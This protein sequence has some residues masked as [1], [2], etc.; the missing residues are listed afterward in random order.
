MS[1][2]FHT[3]A[4]AMEVH[5]SA[6]VHKAN[7]PFGKMFLLGFLAGAFIAFGSAS[8]SAAM[9]SIGVPSLARVVGGIVFPVGLMM[10]VFM[11]GELFTGNCL[12][13]MVVLDKKVTVWQMIVHL[14]VS[15]LSNM[16]GALTVA[17]LI[18][19]SG[20]YD[21][22]AGQLGGFTIQVAVQKSSISF[23]QGVASGILCNTLVCVAILIAAAAKDIAGKIWGIFFPI[24]AFFVAGYEHCIANFYYIPAGILAAGNAEYALKATECYGTDLTKIAELSWGDLWSNIIPV[25]I[26]NVIG[27]VLFV[28]ITLYIIHRR[29]WKWKHKRSIDAFAEMMGN[30]SDM[31]ELEEGVEDSAE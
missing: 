18:F 25:T 11:G 6:G 2:N 7:L 27:G 15:F 20:Q 10:V 16:L 9:Y 1:N 28:G 19:A 8:S 12:V 13:T 21:L 30:V 3:P 23:G 17:V 31:E 14:I 22:A 4:E 5:M 24:W 26:G 29:D